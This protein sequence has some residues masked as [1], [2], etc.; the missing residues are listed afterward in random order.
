VKQRNRLPAVEALLHEK[1][2]ES[3]HIE[4]CEEKKK[5]KKTRQEKRKNRQLFLTNKE[6][7]SGP[8]LTEILLR[9]HIRQSD[10][11]AQSF[12]R[13]APFGRN[14]VGQAVELRVSTQKVTEKI[15]KQIRRDCDKLSRTQRVICLDDPLQKLN[16]WPNARRDKRRKLGVSCNLH[17]GAH[18]KPRHI[19]IVS[20]KQLDQNAANIKV[21][22]ENFPETFK[23]CAQS[24][25]RIKR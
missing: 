24:N 3:F 11:S 6:T 21:L 5:K 16:D 22:H 8:N 17:Q 1:R 4:I 23:S 10:L 7:K 2:S 18:G 9:M 20:R 15:C 12:D 25:V 19:S 14:F 13:L